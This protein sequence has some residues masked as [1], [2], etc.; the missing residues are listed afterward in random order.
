M[1]K[2]NG[3]IIN[4]LQEIDERISFFPEFLDKRL[5]ILKKELQERN[6]RVIPIICTKNGLYDSL[7]FDKVDTITFSITEDNN[8]SIASDENFLAFTEN[9]YSVFNKNGFSAGAFL[10]ESNNSNVT[11]HNDRCINISLYSIDKDLYYLTRQMEEI[12]KTTA[13]KNTRFE[14]SH[15][16]I[17]RS[18]DWF[19]DKNLDI[20]E[21]YLLG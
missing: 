10:W 14:I 19:L 16:S 9:N 21:D 3:N 6:Y 4:E 18:S 7:I 13:I 17:L 2:F 5:K 1:N 20:I 12:S 8:M 15:I 11:I